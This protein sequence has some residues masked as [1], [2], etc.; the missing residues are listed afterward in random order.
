MSEPT[1]IRCVRGLGYRGYRA[2]KGAL[3]GWEAGEESA[4][5]HL[6]GFSSGPGTG[7]RTFR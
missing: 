5:D 1:V 2:F 3:R 6:G 4:F 7:W